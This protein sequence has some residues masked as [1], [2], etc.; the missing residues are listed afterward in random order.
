MS[1]ACDAKQSKEWP[2]R[3]HIPRPNGALREATQK[4]RSL[5]G[6]CCKRLWAEL[7]VVPEPFVV[8]AARSG[9]VTVFASQVLRPAR[10]WVEKAKSEGVSFFP[11]ERRA[12]QECVF[13]KL[14]REDRSVRNREKPD[15][16][17]HGLVAELCN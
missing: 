14:R 3:K 7:L 9:A 12:A 6:N 8:R 2:V 10:P 5:R 16:P 4:E 15:R 1:L 13:E 11:R 17:V